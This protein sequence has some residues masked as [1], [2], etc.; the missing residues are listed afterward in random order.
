MKD[1]TYKKYCLV[2]DEWFINGFNGTK[3]Y[4]KYYPKSSEDTAAVKFFELVRIDKIKIYKDNKTKNT[5]SELQITLE[6]QLLEL[7]ELKRLATTDKEYNTVI[8]ALKEQNKL[9]ALYRDHNEQKST[10]INLS[11]YTDEEIEQ[12]LKEIAND[13]NQ[14]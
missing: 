2:V 3:A 12:K 10:K 1:S 4:Q 7:Q 11:R 9:L 13:P 14:F 5:A 8:N 6:S